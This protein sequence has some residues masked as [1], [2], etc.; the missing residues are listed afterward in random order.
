MI[1]VKRYTPDL[2][3]DLVNFI[4]EI[5]QYDLFNWSSYERLKTKKITYFLAYYKNKIISINGCYNFRDNDWVLFTRQFTIPKY[6]NLLK[7]EKH[8]WSKSIP[9]RFLAIPSLEYCLEHKANGIYFFVNVE[10]E[11]GENNWYNGN[12][13]TRHAE[14]MEKIGVAEYQGIYKINSV[15]QDLYKINVTRIRQVIGDL[16]ACPLRLNHDIR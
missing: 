15:Y 13:P 1:T 6:Y 8:L 14:L 5:K 2:K 10:M 7:R 11:E 4:E 3:D 9:S 12:Y 16:L